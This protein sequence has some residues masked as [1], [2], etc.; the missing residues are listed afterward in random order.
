MPWTQIARRVG[1]HP[2]TISREVTANGGRHPYLTRWLRT[3]FVFVL[4]G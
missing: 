1:R 3:G 4:G 2:T